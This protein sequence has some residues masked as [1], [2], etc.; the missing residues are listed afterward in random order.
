MAV[1]WAIR[2]NS[3]TSLSRDSHVTKISMS[4]SESTIAVRAYYRVNPEATAGFA[5][6]TNNMNLLN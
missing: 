5:Y 1:Y 2:K 3:V 4:Y 6:D